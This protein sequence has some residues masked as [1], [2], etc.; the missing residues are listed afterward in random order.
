[1]KKRKIYPAFYFLIVIMALSFYIFNENKRNDI[2]SI[3]LNEIDQKEFKL[4]KNDYL[5]DFN[6]A[7][8]T[9]KHYY[10]FFEINKK[11]YG[12]NWLDKREDYEKYILES[13]NDRDFY[14]RMNDI[15]S[16]INNWHTH[17]IDES[18]GLAMYLTYYQIPK[19]NWRHDLSKLYEKEE[20]RRR[21]NINNNAI[22]KYIDENVKNSSDSAIPSQDDNMTTEI[23][24]EDDLAYIKIKSML[25]DL[26]RKKDEEI[27]NE[28]L[29]KVK[30]YSNLVI[31]IRG[32]GGGDSRYWQEFLLPKIIDKD[33]QTKTYN[34]I[35]SGELNKKIIKQEN[36]SPD[37]TGFLNQSD[38]NADVKEVLKDFDYYSSNDD[39]IK[40]R[41]DSINFKGDIYL[42][43]DGG[44]YSSSEK[45][46]SFCKETKL[47]K[48]VGTKT[49]GDGIGFD[50][51]QVDLPNSGYILRFSNNLGLSESGSINEMDKT[52]PDI[53]VNEKF[54]YTTNKLVD[55]K[56]I[57]AVIKDAGII[58]E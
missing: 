13:K 41:K 11:L 8:D 10:P 53:Y 36:F 16:E 24:I 29:E 55:Q 57:K 40:A 47:A 58:N 4:S 49:A 18:S 54:T 34:F 38:F 45:L 52:S 56:I 27:L 26:Y 51:M 19:S 43:V 30:N 5:E 46:A 2:N 3:Y 15:L 37:V 28:F 48:L 21:Y 31:D 50:P 12:V 44:V 42:L 23:I 39:I 1:M 17:L 14:N 32:N 22:K 33:Y 25:G 20:V 35:K 9:L 6:Y 7:Y